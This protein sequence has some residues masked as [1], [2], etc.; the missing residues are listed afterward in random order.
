M[1]SALVIPVLLVLL[2]GVLEYGRLLVAEVAVVQIARDAALAGARTAEDEEP[3][4][5][6]TARAGTGLTV[7]GLDAGV[8]RVVVSR[9][10]LPCGEAIQV[11]VS[12]PFDAI[13]PLVP[14]P[15]NVAASTTARLE[16]Q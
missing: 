10:T 1:E 6:A 15:G 9:V 11:Y 16:D 7:A 4:G 14:V 13:V 5:V 2:V 8:S 3:D 12:V